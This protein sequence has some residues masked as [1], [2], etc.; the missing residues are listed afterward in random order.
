MDQGSNIQGL[1]VAA[2]LID[3]SSANI[4][5]GAYSQIVASASSKNSRMLEIFNSTSSV[6]QLA[7]G[8]AGAEVV[9]PFYIMPG[10]NGAIM[11]MISMGQRISVKAVD[12]NATLGLL[13]INQYL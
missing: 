10:G 4:T 9:M 11:C 5:T 12:A 3:T 1:P 2:F 6:L 8:A 7:I 13:I